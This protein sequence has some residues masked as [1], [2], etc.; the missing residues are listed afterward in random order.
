MFRLECRTDIDCSEYY[1]RKKDKFELSEGNSSRKVS[2]A[3]VKNYQIFF[4]C[5]NYIITLQDKILKWTQEKPSNTKYWPSTITH[6]KKNLIDIFVQ[7]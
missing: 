7:K 3:I 6:Q 1:V 2:T 4:Q 5:H